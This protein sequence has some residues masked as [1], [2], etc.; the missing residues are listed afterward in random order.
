MR[1]DEYWTAV[2]TLRLAVA[3]LLDTLSPA[4]WETPSLCEGWR[5]REVAGHLSLV[6]TITTWE[7]IA[8]GPRAGFN[9]NRINTVLAT[10]YGSRGAAQIVTSIRDHAADRRTAKALDTRNSL[11][12]IIVHSQDIARPLKREFPV[13]A[14][15]SHAGLERVWAM[16]WPFHA[17]RRLAGVTLTATD[18]DWTVGTGPEVAGP[19]LA[20]LLLSTGRLA[21]ALDALHG[22]GLSVLAQ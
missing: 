19:A 12:D 22:S 11:F 8:A 7:L 9:P 17:R 18:T 1:E 13:P 16:G 21:A 15:F 6:P 14:E 10:R 2:R 5:V 4:E 3:D 20:L